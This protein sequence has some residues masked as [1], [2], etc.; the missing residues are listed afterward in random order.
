MVQSPM[1]AVKQIVRGSQEVGTRGFCRVPFGDHVDVVSVWGVRPAFAVHFADASLDPVS[2]CSSPNLFGDR[3]SQAVFA[4]QAGFVHA[5][6]KG[7]LLFVGPS[8][9]PRELA[10]L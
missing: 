7:V 5:D 4:G 3:D 2:P 9:Q 8:G 6:E 1:D 10:P